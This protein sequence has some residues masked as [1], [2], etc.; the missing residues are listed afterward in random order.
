[1]EIIDTYAYNFT[2]SLILLTLVIRP[3]WITL[4][5]KRIANPR[6]KEI[7]IAKKES[8]ENKERN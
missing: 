7:R 5:E 6:V 3:F 4:T 2:I 1:M 8:Q